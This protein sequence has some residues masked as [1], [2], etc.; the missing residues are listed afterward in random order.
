MY[1]QV[2]IGKS[3]KTKRCIGESSKTNSDNGKSDHIVFLS[4]QNCRKMLKDGFRR[5][6]R[7]GHSSM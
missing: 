3:S 5:A 6:I 1:Q 7:T 2:C 4:L